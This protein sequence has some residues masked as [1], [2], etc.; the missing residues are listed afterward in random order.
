MSCKQAHKSST[1]NCSILI[2]S[3]LFFV[4][5]SNCGILFRAA[6]DTRRDICAILIDAERGLMAYTLNLMSLLWLF[7]GVITSLY[8]RN[9]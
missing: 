8:M 7:T 1:E 6:V 5:T 3:S 4:T 2:F 9:L